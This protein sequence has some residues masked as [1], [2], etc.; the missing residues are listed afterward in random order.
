MAY[1]SPTEV[2][3]IMRKL[4]SSIQDDSIEFHCEKASSLID[5]L[6]GE[7]YVTPFEPVPAIIKHM[8]TDLAVFFLAEDLYSSSSPNMD[9]YHQKRYDRVMEQVEKIV[10][11]NMSIGVE[12]KVKSGFASTRSDWDDENVF[13]VTEPEW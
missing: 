13:T 12:P 1:T 10:E 4:P 6:L 8:S 2:K 5:S 9:E 7:V 11:G 3:N